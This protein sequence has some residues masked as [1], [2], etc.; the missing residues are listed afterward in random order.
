MARDTKPAQNISVSFVKILLQPEEKILELPRWKVKTVKRLLEELN[1][2]QSTAL[3]A[4]GQELLTPD[5]GIYS[6]DEIL[7][8]KVTSAG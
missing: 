2:T 6:G 7:V 4:R 5:R 1:L 8:R 3:V